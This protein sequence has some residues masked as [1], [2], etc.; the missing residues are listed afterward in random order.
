[1]K[2]FLKY[3]ALT[4]LILLCVCV[5]Y[6]THTYFF[7]V[8]E[9]RNQGITESVRIG[10]QAYSVDEGVVLLEDVRINGITALRALRIAYGKAL[11][12]RSPL[13]GLEGTNPEA[14]RANTL[15]L[16][17]TM[18]EIS[19][20]QNTREDSEFVKN[21]LYP[22]DFLYS[23]ATLESARK[24][25][26]ASGSELDFNSYNNSLGP[27][28]KSGIKDSK[29]LLGA[30]VYETRS[31]DS[32]RLVGF[33]GTMTAT[34]SR[35]SL[36]SIPD[37]LA[38]MKRQAT[39]RSL[40]LLGVTWVCPTLSPPTIPELQTTQ[41]SQIDAGT[42]TTFDTQIGSILRSVA[43]TTTYDRLYAPVRLRKSACLASLPP[44]YHLE[45]SILLRTNFDLLHYMNDLYFI[46]TAGRSGP[47]PEF[48][49]NGYGLKYL[50]INPMTFYLCPHLVE[51][52]SVAQAILQTAA[53]AKKH[54]D[55]PNSHRKTLIAGV[56]T[57]GDAIAYIREATDLA[58]D[59]SLPAEYAQEILS[60]AL[61]FNQRS[62]GLDA[63]V[64][65]IT[66]IN[67]HDLALAKAGA[68]F[69]LNAETLFQTHTAA[70]SLFLFRQIGALS[71][72]DT[73][74]LEDWRTL[75]KKFESYSNLR[76]RVTDDF[77][78]RQIRIMDNLEK[79][80]L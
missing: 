10:I 43:A 66:Y 16:K 12:E 40:C 45:A 34:S 20:L 44:P 38:R 28:F 19:L 57:G 29:R 76:S 46:P 18:D 67:Q 49:R 54:D 2:T 70:P 24:Q 5:A 58:K 68:P 42:R 27:V 78:I 25:F 51:D 69:D 71:P 14:L 59:E 4:T 33:S 65:Q 32:P 36:A 9:L 6:G 39:K 15:L 47:V 23:L 64:A 7:F 55:I 22:I 52:L 41:P 11:A 3:S 62:A 75:N 77:I 31:N 21:A 1:M 72:L 13:M 63:V 53:I 80:G 37:S 73:A 74:T 60:T 8:R 48:L 50:K 17:K 56:P 26:I 79:K 30:F 35:M 61:I